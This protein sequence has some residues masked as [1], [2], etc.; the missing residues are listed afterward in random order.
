V[1]LFC[2]GCKKKGEKKKKCFKKVQIK[3]HYGDDI[4]LALIDTKAG[5]A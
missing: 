3:S 1:W 4:N 2:V 5:N